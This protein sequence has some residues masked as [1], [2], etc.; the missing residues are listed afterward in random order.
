MTIAE[1]KNR[2]DYSKNFDINPSVYVNETDY[3]DWGVEFVWLEDM[4]RGAEYNICM[5]NG[6]NFS[7]IYALY[8]DEYIETDSNTFIHYEI[9]FSDPAWEQKLEDAMCSAVIK[10]NKL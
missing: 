1:I 3:D 10:F 7:A 2:K 6:E 5:D 9:N 4:N 8:E